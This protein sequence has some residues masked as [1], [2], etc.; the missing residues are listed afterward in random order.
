MMYCCAAKNRCCAM[1]SLPNQYIITMEDRNPEEKE[2]TA[3]IVDDEPDACRNLAHILLDYIAPGI[4]IAGMAH[5][6]AAAATLIKTHTPDVVFLDIE[7]PQEN[8]FA[9]LERMQPV[10]FEIILVT[11][12]DEYAVRAFRLNALDYILKPIDITELGNAMRR[13]QDR[14][15]YR[16]IMRENALSYSMP[17]LPVPD[18]I[19]PGKI[20]LR[21]NGSIEIVGFEDIIFIEARGSYS[22]ICFLKNGKEKRMMMSRSV[23]EFEDLL[24][25]SLFYRIHKSF[26]VNCQHIK[27]ILKGDQFFVQINE[28]TRLPVGRRRCSSLVAF[29]KNNTF[30]YA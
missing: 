24:P 1:F 13:V 26:L 10:S 19:K 29:L 23:S 8:A 16:D 3:V 9:F 27:S 2:L 28:S 6:T 18:M 15:R 11:A 5:D 25:P 30:G 22:N 20:T 17:P 12:Y 4:R 14:L 21:D 7:M